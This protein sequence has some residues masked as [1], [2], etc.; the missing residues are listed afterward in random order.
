M[1]SG[2]AD[3]KSR[4]GGNKPLH[5]LATPCS[6][7]CGRAVSCT[8]STNP[9]CVSSKEDCLG[10]LRTMIGNF[11]FHHICIFDGIGVIVLPFAN[12]LEIEAEV[13]VDGWVVRLP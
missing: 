9:T 10:I 3:T 7:F 12:D 5:Y 13:E 4:P 8:V 11:V 6:V 1:V 2:F